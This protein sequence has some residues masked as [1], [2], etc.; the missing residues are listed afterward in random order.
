MDA[1]A[2]TMTGLPPA[3]SAEQIQTLG[4]EGVL[5]PFQQLLR[6]IGLKGKRPRGVFPSN[7]LVT[8]KYTLISFLPKN[9]YEQF[10]RV[11]N[12]YFLMLVCLQVR[13]TQDCKVEGGKSW[14]SWK[15]LC[16]IYG[17]SL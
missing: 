7:E 6:R 12:M 10:K 14:L 16:K 2:V 13:A 11:A 17:Q 9:L 3:F 5:T 8:S 15:A 4:G 1:G